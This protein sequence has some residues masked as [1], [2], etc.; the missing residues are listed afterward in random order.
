MA[1]TLVA[2]LTALSLS[3]CPTLTQEAVSYSSGGTESL[4]GAGPD[5]RT[6]MAER[7]QDGW[8]L[9]VDRSGDEGWLWPD[10]SSESCADTDTQAV[11]GDPQWADSTRQSDNASMR[12]QVV[13]AARPSDDWNSCRQRAGQG[14][15]G[16]TTEGLSVPASEVDGGSDPGD[17]GDVG[18]G[19][20]PAGGSGPIQG[21]TGSNPPHTQTRDVGTRTV[22]VRLTYYTYNSG[23]T[24]N[25]G[26]VYMGST[27]C[28]LNFAFGTKF[29]LPDGSV[30]TCN[31]RGRLYYD[32]NR[33]GGWLDVYAR[34]DIGRL[35]AGSVTVLN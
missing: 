31:D 26:Q 9:A 22:Y 21:D 2:A 34:S 15:Q 16:A 32:E 7:S 17:T 30:V 13:S 25:G 29:V 6:T 14:E 28:S 18:S 23:V 12:R 20:E 1:R 19:Q 27:A 11:M 35:G 10:Q 8:M 5:R 4:D 33:Y 24:A 3:V